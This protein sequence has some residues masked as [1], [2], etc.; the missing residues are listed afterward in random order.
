MAVETHTD[1][2]KEDRYKLQDAR[3]GIAEA[4]MEFGPLNR[5]DWQ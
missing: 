2:K 3:K 1:E 5:Q 4:E